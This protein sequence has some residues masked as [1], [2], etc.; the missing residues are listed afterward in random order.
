M[1]YEYTPSGVC[2]QK[3]TFTIENNKITS[4]SIVGGCPGN[5]KAVCKLLI[6]MEVTKAINTLKGIDCRNRGTSCPDQ[7]AKALLSIKK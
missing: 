3:F 2:A 4:F 1:Q 7:I 5:T 6:G